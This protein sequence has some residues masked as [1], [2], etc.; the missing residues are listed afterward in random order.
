[1][2]QVDGSEYYLPVEG[3]TMS[4]LLP[5]DEE[6]KKCSSWHRLTSVN[7]VWRNAKAVAVELCKAITEENEIEVTS[8]WVINGARLEVIDLVAG[9]ADQPVDV[10]KGINMDIASKQKAAIAGTT[11]CGKSTTLLVFLRLLEPRRGT[12]VI[13]G[14]NV[15]S[16]GLRTL[17]ASL[18]L[19]PQDPVIFSGTIRTN[20]DPFEKL[21]D[22]QIWKALVAVHLAEWAFSRGGGLE[23]PVSDRDISFGE[24][25]LLCIA[26]MILRQP[27]LL[28]LDEATSAIDPSTQ[29]KVQ[30]AIRTQFPDSTVVAIAHRLET[31]MDFDLVF[32]FEKGRVV[33]KGKP[34]E[35]ASTKGTV[36]GNMV[37]AKQSAAKARLKG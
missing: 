3:K 28:L 26:R 13:N 31:I 11:G 5:K 18:G 35:L 36:F 15:A 8:G 1:L 7:R 10:L 16:L 22:E 17:R 37:A 23:S 19:V 6:L 21:T 25:Q 34:M 30:V 29:E 14:V 4:D 9:Y 33:E 12:I 20:L 2:R 27:A 32:V 24:A